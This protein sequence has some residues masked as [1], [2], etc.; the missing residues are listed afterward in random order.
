MPG[1]TGPDPEVCLKAVISVVRVMYFRPL[2]MCLLQ[3]K[4]AGGSCPN[5]KIL[6]QIGRRDFLLAPDAQVNLQPEHPHIGTSSKDLA[7][8]PH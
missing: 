4:G 2:T 7:N 1:R 3:S 5:L 6:D 8:V